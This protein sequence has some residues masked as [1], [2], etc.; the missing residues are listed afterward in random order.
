ME[1]IVYYGLEEI[2][3]FAMKT[4]KKL[5]TNTY[6][7]VFIPHTIYKMRQLGFDIELGNKV[8]KD[9]KDIL[10]DNIELFYITNRI[11]NPMVL[12]SI[13]YAR[14]DML[15]KMVIEEH[16]KADINKWLLIVLNR[17]I[18]VTKEQEEN[19]E[20]KAKSFILKSN[21]LTCLPKPK[22]NDEVEQILEINENGEVNF[23]AYKYNGENKK[24]TL[25]REENLT[26]IKGLIKEILDLVSGL[27]SY[28]YQD[29]EDLIKENAGRWEV[30][31]NSEYKNYFYTGNLDR[32]LKHEGINLS[33]KIRSIIKIKN[34]FLFDN[35]KKE[36][37]INRIEI[38]YKRTRKDYSDKDKVLEHFE[39][40]I[41]DR[42]SKSVEHKIQ[43][44]SQINDQIEDEINVIKKY[45]IEDVIE[46]V[47]DN[48][49]SKDIFT[50][51]EGNPKGSILEPK[52]I[53]TYSANITFE[54]GKTRGI[55]GSYDK[56]SLPEDWMQFLASVVAVFSFFGKE[57]LFDDSIF[58]QNIRHKTD[59]IY[60]SVSFGPE[61]YKTYYYLTDDDNIKIGD[62]VFVPAGKDNEVKLTRVEKKEYFNQLFVPFP[63]DKIKSVLEIYDGEVGTEEDEPLY[64]LSYVEK[65]DAMDD[66]VDDEE[67]DDNNF[68][69]E[70]DENEEV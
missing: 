8:F 33:D 28:S 20:G 24:L 21:N 16:I 26:I 43:K 47:L 3:N 56:R 22:I 45:K 59:K 18:L 14:L 13:V 60:L 57:D 64:E 7:K 29:A 25:A 44:N 38:E 17:L 39:T 41:L 63:L 48:F 31:V 19:F 65:T 62:F 55:K 69:L 4:Y 12:G 68:D 36:D 35:N 40:L 2:H 67:Q 1:E 27:F 49:D 6:D 66:D 23:K 10:I 54:S 37:K 70:D 34:L 50:K 9:H 11:N 32:H 5:K 52:D 61:T 30:K 42:K 15:K 53:K 46:G 51:I 58:N